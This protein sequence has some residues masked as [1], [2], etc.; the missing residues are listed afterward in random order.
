MGWQFSILQ[1]FWE[2]VQPGP[3]YHLLTI[4]CSWFLWHI[5]HKFGWSLYELQLKDLSVCCIFLCRLK[6]TIS[7]VIR[8][9]SDFLHV[10]ACLYFYL[11]S[12]VS[13]FDVTLMLFAGA[14]DVEFPI[15][16]TAS[17]PNLKVKSM[18]KQKLCQ[19]RRNS[20]LM[21]RRRVNTEKLYN[22]QISGMNIVNIYSMTWCVG[23]YL[24]SYPLQSAIW[25]FHF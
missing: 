14:R 25:S 1:L 12:H 9:C 21:A 6:Q 22:T 19:E 17:E 20:P 13:R 3:W 10:K 8:L 4:K 15:R 16:K 24:R 5:I 11:L 18:L 2:C 23:L 7:V